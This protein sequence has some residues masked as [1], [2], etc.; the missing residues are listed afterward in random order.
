MP[1]GRI[2]Q[3]RFE[4]LAF[5]Q[6]AFPNHREV[7]ALVRIRPAVDWFAHCFVPSPGYGLVCPVLSSRARACRR[8]H[9]VPRVPLP[10]VGITFIRESS[11][12][13]FRGHY[14]PFIAHTDSFANP[15]WLSPTSAFGLV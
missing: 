12:R 11:N 4:T 3:V 6:Y 2:S 10:D 5:R 8:N 13:L 9:Q 14:S 7:Q 15:M 1:Y